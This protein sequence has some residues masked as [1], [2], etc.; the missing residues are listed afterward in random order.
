MRLT[1]KHFGNLLGITPI[2]ILVYGFILSTLHQVFPFLVSVLVINLLFFFILPRI[3]KFE[4]LKEIKEGALAVFK[5][6]NHSIVWLALV[7]VY[8]LGV[9]FVFVL[10]RLV[11]KKF[12]KV[13]GQSSWEK[14][15][16]NSED[17]SDM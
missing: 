17:Y 16:S 15:S 11:G 1:Y 6:I 2:M 9:G 12:I 7:G 5:K 8:I 13:A 3:F 4:W 14:S 10:S